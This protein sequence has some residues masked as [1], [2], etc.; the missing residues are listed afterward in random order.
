MGD[1]VDE[2]KAEIRAV[3]FDLDVSSRLTSIHLTFTYTRPFQTPNLQGHAP[4]HRKLSGL[5]CNRFLC[6]YRHRHTERCAF[7]SERGWVSP[8]LGPKASAVGIARVR[9]D[10]DHHELCQTALERGHWV[11]LGRRMGDVRQTP[12][13]YR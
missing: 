1:H 12:K 8:P 5:G 6:A 4:G 11:R 3:I 10:P 13:A 2:T 7:G 9:M